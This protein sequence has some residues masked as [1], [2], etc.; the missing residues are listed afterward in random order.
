MCSLCVDAAFARPCRLLDD[1]RVYA[2]RALREFEVRELNAGGTPLGDSCL[3]TAGSFLAL[4]LPF[5]S[6]AG[7]S[8]PATLPDLG[9]LHNNGTND[10]AILKSCGLSRL[11]RGSAASS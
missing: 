8:V 10:G 5:D 9:P 4:Y 6:A 7:A 11:H 2:G 3:S 1:V